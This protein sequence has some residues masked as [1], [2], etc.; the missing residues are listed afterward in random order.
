MPVVEVEPPPVLPPDTLIVV[1]PVLPGSVVL[2]S[3]V[4]AV[5]ES[6]VESVVGS[7]DVIEVAVVDVLSVPP[8]L[9]AESVTVVGEPEVLSLVESLAEPLA[10]ET[11]V[12]SGPQAHEA[13]TSTNMPT[14]RRMRG[15]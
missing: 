5:V 10:G 3:V 8:V 12:A 1:P 2:E 4:P 14:G 11:S 7:I 15:A 6:V 13:K 9:E